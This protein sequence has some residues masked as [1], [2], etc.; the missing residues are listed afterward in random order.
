[1]PLWKLARPFAAA[2]F[3]AIAALAVPA[4]S[5]S[6]QIH[7]YQL[8][9]SLSDIYGG[10]SLVANGGVRSSSGYTFGANQGL[11]LSSVFS[12][13]ASYSIAIRSMY[14]SVNTFR[15]GYR[16]MVDF[17]DMSAD[18]G[19]YDRTGG[20]A[21]FWPAGTGGA[22][23]TENVMDFTVL[24]RSAATKEFNAYVNGNQS[25]TF[26]DVGDDATFSGINGI[27]RFFE[28][29]VLSRQIEEAAGVVT[30]IAVYDRVLSATEVS[31]LG[32]VVATPEPAP[33]V[34]LV[35]GLVGLGI[36]ARRRR[37]APSTAAHS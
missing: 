33:I 1:M 13:S 30:Y 9:T 15:L 22:P 4:A 8:T 25:L 32:E 3:A 20:I 10:P 26:T 11:S 31:Q 6:A 24:T 5:A 37:G 7:V 29:D 36:V 21:E 23:Y 2:S 16:K 18:A 34:L 19:W 12:A 35:T 27:A 14:T 28:D 17:K